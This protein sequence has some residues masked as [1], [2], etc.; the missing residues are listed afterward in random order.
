MTYDWS[1]ITEN[2]IINLIKEG[3]TLLKNDNYK[4][5]DGAEDQ[6]ILVKLK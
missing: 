2:S 5:T 6:F 4:Y 1:N 3:Y